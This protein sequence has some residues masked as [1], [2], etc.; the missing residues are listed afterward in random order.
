MSIAACSQCGNFVDTD[1]DD[2]FY[3]ITLEN[4]QIKQR[5]NGLCATC[6]ETTENSY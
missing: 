2:D 6:R 5:D 4:G 1:L 3:Y